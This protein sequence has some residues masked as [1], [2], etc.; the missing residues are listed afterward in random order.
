MSKS[1]GN[2]VD[3]FKL[4]KNQDINSIRLYF[5]SNGPQNHDVD[6]DEKSVSKIYYNHIPDKLSN[7]LIM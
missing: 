1:I 5:L 7:Y 6:F 2:I 4:M 3:P